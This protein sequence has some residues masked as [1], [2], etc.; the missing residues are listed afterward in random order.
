M[1][2]ICTGNPSAASETSTCL[3]VESFLQFASVIEDLLTRRHDP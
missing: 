3:C 2:K 1:E